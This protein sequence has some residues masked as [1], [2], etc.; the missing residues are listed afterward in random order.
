M[1]RDDVP[2]EPII[3]PTVLTTEALRREIGLLEAEVDRRFRQLQKEL[4]VRLEAERLMTEVQLAKIEQHFEIN[5]R[6]RQE[7][8]EAT[9]L[10]IA[11]ALQSQKEA[12]SKS[13]TA[14]NRQ[15]EQL[16]ATFDTRVESLRRS[17]DENKERLVAEAR[18]LRASISQVDAK[19]ASF[20][21]QRRG[22]DATRT[23]LFGIVAAIVGVVGVLVAIAAFAA[24]S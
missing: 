13:E 16:T 21:Q 14:T 20:V 11:A 8:K 17:I 9:Q 6:H 7:T 5:R 1:D 19:A 12:V 15:L 10:A 3:D 23:Q 24:R 18:E 4:A 2:R 22:S